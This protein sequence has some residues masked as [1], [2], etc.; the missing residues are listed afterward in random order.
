M[1]TAFPQSKPYRKT[2]Q[3]LQCP[4]D[5]A[6]EVILCLFCCI[7]LVTQTSPH[8]MC[9]G[10]YR[11]MKNWQ[12]RSLGQIRGWLLHVSRKVSTTITSFNKHNIYKAQ[13]KQDLLEPGI[14]ISSRC[15]PSH[16]C[17]PEYCQDLW[18]HIF[19]A[20]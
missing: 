5:L 6:S 15:S 10:L 11:L 3:K 7:L 13:G 20:S 9:E 19:R 8:S 1:V 16:F 17:F 18:V 14:L 4:D 2:W 12:L